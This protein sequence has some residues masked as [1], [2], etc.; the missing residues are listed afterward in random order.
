MGTFR[1]LFWTIAMVAAI[2]SCGGSDDNNI[3]T[4]GIDTEP[5]STD[6]INTTADEPNENEPTIG[7][8]DSSGDT[9]DTVDSDTD[10]TAD[11]GTANGEPVE[12][13][14]TTGTDINRLNILSGD[15]EVASIDTPVGINFSTDIS[16]SGQ[17]VVY[18]NLELDDIYLRDFDAQTTTRISVGVNG[19]MSNDN[20]G[21]PKF[22]R[23]GQF[24]S[25]RS[26]AT[27]LIDNDTNF[28]QD[29]FL[30]PFGAASAQK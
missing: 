3:Q 19:E 17:F 4:T 28:K 11:S 6:G 23:S 20:S 24:I 29:V 15:I 25:F 26:S 1:N 13:D 30:Y 12:A 18:Q 8:G 22:S 27:N 7:D 10:T 14:I 5:V 9:I 16:P 21:D 2:S